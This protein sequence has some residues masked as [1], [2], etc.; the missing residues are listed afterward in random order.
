MKP[1]DANCFHCGLPVERGSA[2]RA[3]VFGE[4]RNFCCPGCRAVCEAIVASGNGDYYRHRSAPSG[5]PVDGEALREQLA[6]L[7]L[8]DDPGL[9]SRFVRQE[10]GLREAA[11]ILEEI[12]CPA[13]LWLNEQQLRRLDGV[14]DVDLDY[15][16]Q[17]AR[18]RW[19]P[20]RIRLSEILEAIA[21]IGYVA[22]PFDPAHRDALLR[23][24]RQR[25]VQ[26]ILFALLLG[27][28]VM[29]FS[30]ST[31][32]LGGPDADGVLPLWERIGRWTGLLLTALLLAYPGQLFF[33]NAW[34]DLRHGR[35]G[36]DV[37]VALGLSMA[38]LASLHA[39][40]TEQGDVYFESIAMF[41]LFM[42]VARH[43][44]LK[45]R[46]KGAAALDRLARVVPEQVIRLTPDGEE[47]VLVTALQPGDRVRVL[48]GEPVPADARIVQGRSGFDESLLS[49]EA[50]PVKRGEGDTVPGGAVNTTQPVTVEVVRRFVD[51][52]L[53]RIGD[54][55]RHALADRPGYVTLANRVAGR[56]VAGILVVA[57]LTLAFWSW[58]DPAVAWPATVAVLIVTCPCALALASPVASTLAAAGLARAGVL[59]LRMSALEPLATADTLVMDKTGTLTRGRPV[60]HQVLPRPGME[61]ERALAIAAVLEA[62]SEHPIAAALRDAGP[63]VLPEMRE[64]RNSPGEGVSGFLDGT[65]WRLGS[66]RF[67]TG[68][69]SQE[70]AG[71]LPGELRVCLGCNGEVRA[72]FLLRDALRPGVRELVAAARGLGIER[73]VILSGDRQ[74]Q[75][76]RVAALVDVD[77]GHG[78]LLPQQKLAWLR[79]AQRQGRRVVTLGDGINDAPVLAGADVSVS[80]AEATRLAQVHSDFVILERRLSAL[81]QALVLARRTRRVIRQNLGW[82]LGYNLLAIPLAA[83]GLVAPWGAAIG[84]TLSSLAVI[85]N[86]LRLQ[87]AAGDARPR[88]GEGCAGSIG[89]PA[90]P[91][92]QDKVRWA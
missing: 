56:F 64:R 84:M 70:G 77:E 65:E 30:F 81:A 47:Q 19:D 61:A 20:A 44:E 67:V 40:V 35:L 43:L 3:E 41:V 72:E 14:V 7:R 75:V 2:Q 31:Y 45:A 78:D 5:R 80:V 13:C 59:P 25:S 66:E 34:R 18:V 23:E 28:M 73:I 60:L 83:A 6:K 16:S 17:Q 42:L 53:H 79:E 92:A 24:Q 82:A 91:R 85:G 29:N 15:T 33:R 10:G 38:W 12:H 1:A 74:A 76:D 4:Q 32:Y 52:S 39:T 90:R 57:A 86:S 8:F 27:M 11:L 54:L 51:S 63:S 87:R 22:H 48:P 26:R 46:L 88:S 69:T 37:P 71:A 58:L 68:R 55:T 36:M 50:L 62:E 49:G 21:A 9:Q 89:Q